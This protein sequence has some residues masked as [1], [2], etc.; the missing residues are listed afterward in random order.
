M[1]AGRRCVAIVA[2]GAT[3]ACVTATAQVR[4][5]F[6][7]ADVHASAVNRAVAAP[8]MQGNVV[9]DGVYKIQNATMVDL[10]RT[11][12]SIDGENVL[13]GPSWLEWDRFVIQ[14]KV[15]PSTSADTTRQMLQALLADRFALVLHQ[16]SRPMPGFALRVPKA[17]AHKLKRADGSGRS[18][19]SWTALYSDAEIGA[20]RQ[21]AIQ[22]GENPVLLQT[23]VQ[24]CRNMTMT[25]FAEGM[26][27][28]AGAQQYFDAGVVVDQTG[29]SGEW[30]FDFRYSQ[31]PLSSAAVSVVGGEP[32]TIVDAIDKQLGL[33]LESTAIP[34][35]V[36]IV[37]RV[38]RTPSDNPPG[39]SAM[40]PLPPPPAF[41]VA[42]LR[43]S[44]PNAPDVQSNGPLPGGRFE[45]RNFP[46]R[47]LITIGWPGSEL[48]NAP[49][50]LGSVRVDLTAKLPSTE[51]TR[52]IAGVMDINAFQPALRT[53]LME[54]FK[55]SIRTEQ[56]PWSGY[57][58]MAA[59][60]RLQKADPAT[61]TKCVEGPGADGKDPRASNV[62][63]SRLVTCRNM[64]MQQFAEELPRLSRGSIGGE[65]LDATGVTGAYD[66]TLSFSGTSPSPSQ[67]AMAAAG[68]SGAPDPGGA[69][70]LFAALERQLGLK[71][72]KRNI[73]MRVNVLDHIEEKP[74]DN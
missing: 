58:L 22:A 2:L 40:L 23:H 41:E 30:D 1:N 4:P 74:T 61:R 63:L 68:Q 46:L 64:T 38:N 37:D 71:L 67:A 52:E 59:K 15:P 60:P 14:A 50:W 43:L 65:V 26:R 25:A 36:F 28:M 8:T 21:A 66:F 31:K 47:F 9:R 20:R 35:P 45:V 5:Q 48:V 11:A 56:R 44:D 39:V 72:E 73:P 6:D 55:V 3:L 62:L 24:A 49:D 19:C 18:G 33:R 10:I 32:I 29:L 7:L 69:V 51:A 42:S 13:G 17:G 53:L 70:T 57:A 12:Y 27:N 16:E 54:R 34:R